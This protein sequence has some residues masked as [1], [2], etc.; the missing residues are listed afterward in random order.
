MVG[1][2]FTAWIPQLH[3]PECSN[4][5]QATSQCKGATTS[6]MGFLIMSLSLLSIGSG[7]IRPC[8][9]PF[10]VDQFDTTSEEGRK[11]LGSFYNWYYATFSIILVFTATVVVYIQDSVSWVLGYGIPTLLM[12]CAIVLFFLGTRVYVYMK[13]EGS[14]FTGLARVVVATYKK[15]KLKLSSP[16]ATD[17]KTP[18]FYDPPLDSGTAVIPKLP[19]TTQYR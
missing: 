16:D 6:Q 7:G 10:G 5:L 8:S 11:G 13:P 9:V 15:R 17:A 4:P 1:M 12:F 19:L 2:T 14:V 3:P 18:T